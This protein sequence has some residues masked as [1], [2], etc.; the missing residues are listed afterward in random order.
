MDGQQVQ[1]AIAESE[2]VVLS[3]V[4]WDYRNFKEGLGCDASCYSGMIRELVDTVS[5]S[6]TKLVWHTELWYALTPI[7]ELWYAFTALTCVAHRA[8][9]CVNGHNRLS[10]D[11]KLSFE[12][13]SGCDLVHSSR[14]NRIAGYIQLR[15]Q[16]THLAATEDCATL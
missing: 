4:I 12:L 6:K 2:I 11:V 1:R 5:I 3:S 15:R 10:A 8:V 14:A 9:V 16:G 13:I 7:T